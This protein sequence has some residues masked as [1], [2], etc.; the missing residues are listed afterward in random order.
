MSLLKRPKILND[1]VALKIILAKTVIFKKIADFHAA[2]CFF[3]VIDILSFNSMIIW[4][5]KNP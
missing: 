3:S 2:I 1:Q 5:L 4:I